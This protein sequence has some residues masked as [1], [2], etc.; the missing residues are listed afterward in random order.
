[1]TRRFVPWLVL[2]GAAGAAVVTTLR[3]IAVPWW[4]EWGRRAEDDGPLAG[5]DLVAAPTAI[6]T[7]G[8]DIAAPPEAVWPWLTQMGYGRAGWY[9]YDALDMN[10]PSADDLRPDLGTAVGDVMPTHPGGGFA[11]RIVDP[12]HALVLYSDTDL[13]R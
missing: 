3:L 13:V 7:R 12:P 4:R 11:V 6:E 2:L 10:A 1:M 5:D 8:I 9:S